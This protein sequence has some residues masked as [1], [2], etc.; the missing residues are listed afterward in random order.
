MRGP[1]GEVPF[2]PWLFRIAINLA[3]NHVRDAARW[4]A[5]P[6]E[7]ADAAGRAP[8]T[9]HQ[10]YER[11]EAEALTRRAVLRLPRRQREVFGLRIDAGLAFAEVAEVLGITEGNAKAHF[12][13]AVTRLRLEVQG[14]LAPPRGAR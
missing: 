4:V 7:A 2:R 14:M 12:H 8:D 10:A 1:E 6:V 13:H 9:A 5:A 11:A 3:K